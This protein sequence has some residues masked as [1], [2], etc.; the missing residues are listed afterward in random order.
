MIE[1]MKKMTHWHTESFN[2]FPIGDGYEVD[3]NEFDFKDDNGICYEQG[4]RGH[5]ALASGPRQGRCLGLSPRLERS[6]V[7]V[8]GRWPTRMLIP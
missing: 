2:A 7:R 3:V 8:D 1:G 6:F 4:R 5:P